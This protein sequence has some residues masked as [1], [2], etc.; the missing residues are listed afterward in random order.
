MRGIITHLVLP[1]FNFRHIYALQERLEEASELN[2][3][4][5]LNIQ[6]V[7]PHEISDR[8]QGK[9]FYSLR[10]GPGPKGLATFHEY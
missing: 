1:L 2:P 9:A 10:E 3:P 7:I 8:V 6:S 4:Q 5:W